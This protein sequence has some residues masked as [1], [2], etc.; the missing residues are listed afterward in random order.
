MVTS[1][2]TNIN[3]LLCV[4]LLFFLSTLSVGSLTTLDTD[5][6]DI[7]TTHPQESP[8]KKKLK[9][10]KCPFVQAAFYDYLP[11]LSLMFRETA[12]V[13]SINNSNSSTPYPR[14]KNPRL[15]LYTSEFFVTEGRKDHPDELN[16]P[17]YIAVQMVVYTLNNI[18]EAAGQSPISGGLDKNAD[19]VE[20][21]KNETNE[22]NDVYGSIARQYRDN[23]VFYS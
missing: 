15:L 4:L 20:H 21:E 3:L 13:N 1:S 6:N 10:Y 19:Q 8:T 9:R 16:V 7:I 23:V 5:E 18:I 17:V 14:K 12:A 2:T 11:K 22:Q